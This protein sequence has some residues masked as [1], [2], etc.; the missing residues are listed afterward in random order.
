MLHDK[1]DAPRNRVTTPRAPRSP[2]GPGVLPG[3]GTEGEGADEHGRPTDGAAGWP[4]SCRPH[5]PRVSG[6]GLRG[7]SRP[8]V[9]STTPSPSM[10]TAPPGPPRWTGPS[11]TRTGAVYSTVTVFST[12]G[13]GDI[14]PARASVR[15]NDRHSTAA[16]R[17]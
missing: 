14:V 3:D 12:V 11:L 9:P 17:R 1:S 7:A 8:R 4:A 15:L 13:F 10:T 16:Q 5:R 6:T 2:Q